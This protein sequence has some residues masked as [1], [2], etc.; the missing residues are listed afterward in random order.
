MAEKK[1]SLS[2]L[3]LI[4]GLLVL[5]IVALILCIYFFFQYQRAQ[6]LLR[7]PAA[8]EKEEGARIVEI[9]RSVIAMPNNEMPTV[10]TVADVNKLKQQPFFSQAQNGDKVLVF[11]SS[12][13]VIL[14]RPSTRKVIN[15]LVPNNQAPTQPISDTAT[16]IIQKQKEAQ[17]KVVVLNGS[18]TDGLAGKT[19]E[20]L[21]KNYDFIT[22]VKKESAQKNTY[23]KTVVVY[24]SEAHKKQAEHIAQQLDGQIT[25]SMPLGEKEQDADMVIIVA[26]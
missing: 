14:Y 20:S 5:S 23:E 1:L 17:A 11:N 2:K 26:Q 15:M 25:S 7:N 22:V 19:A 6:Q 24:L 10:A 18:K 4:P 3:Y 16:P 8:A 21:E 13:M 12:K 9:I